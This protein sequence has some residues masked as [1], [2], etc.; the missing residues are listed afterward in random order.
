[1]KSQSR[2]PSRR[3]LPWRGST[4]VI[5]LFLGV[6]ILP[7]L[8]AHLLTPEDARVVRS[9][10]AYNGCLYVVHPGENLFRIG[11]RY[12]VSYV[13]LAQVNG[14][15]NPNVIYAGQILSVPCTLYGPYNPSYPPYPPARPLPSGCKPPESYTVVPGDNL[16]RIAVNYGSTIV[17][18]RNANHLWG[19]VLRPGM[20]L[21]VPCPGA[22]KYRP[23]PPLTPGTPSIITATPAPPPPSN[24]V[25][26]RNNNLRPRRLTVPVGTTVTWINGDAAG[27][28]SYTVNSGT[29]QNP[30]NF[31]NSNPIPPGGTFQ[32]RFTVGGLYEYY[33]GTSPDVTGTIEVTQ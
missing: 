28:N 4:L 18:I 31:F 20:V 9:V 12:G 27:G 33:L 26:I 14:I 15:P 24:A 23:I 21:S 22:V 11:F 1:M 5:M 10:Q 19:R 17:W 2:R 32:Y 25:T 3:Q 7:A 16:F 29:P 13:Y 30:T 6:A 8:A